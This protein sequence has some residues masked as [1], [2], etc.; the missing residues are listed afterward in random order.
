MLI[1][2]LKPEELS[3]KLSIHCPIA[4]AGKS[5]MGKTKSIQNMSDEDKAETLIIN[6]DNK[7]YSNNHKFAGIFSL[8]KEEPSMERE[9]VFPSDIDSWYA[10]K[11]YFY[12]ALK[13]TKIKRIIID[14]LTN[15]DHYIQAVAQ[16]M[17]IST[18]DKMS[19]W[20]NVAVLQA[21]L[22]H[23]I[24]SASQYNTICYAIAHINRIKDENNGQA[25]I[26][27]T[28]NTYKYRVETNFQTV[29]YSLKND[30]LNLFT[31]YAN[32]LNQQDKTRVNTENNRVN[33]ARYSLI[34]LEDVLLSKDSKQMKS[35][36][37][38]A[39]E[40]AEKDLH[41]EYPDYDDIFLDSSHD[42]DTLDFDNIKKVKI[43]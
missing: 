40:K 31:F 7:G 20:R 22:F 3:M 19:V 11:D 24:T 35:I 2:Q 16:S 41:K 15:A 32:S 39:R 34:D 30:D 10:F 36:V 42:E 28:G 4:I 38:N 26:P 37:E 18:K 27:I 13:N 25:Y 17:L 12:K 9:Y 14:T 29:V 1:N 6:A 43:N 8:N 33:F 21:D 5:G 23:L